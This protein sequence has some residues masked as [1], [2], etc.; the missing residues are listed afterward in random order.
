MNAAIQDL[1]Q[2]PTL[3]LWAH[4]NPAAKGTL[5]NTGAS[6]LQMREAV[7]VLAVITPAWSPIPTL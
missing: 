6:A 2:P 1:S 5:S 4:T 7:T 3:G